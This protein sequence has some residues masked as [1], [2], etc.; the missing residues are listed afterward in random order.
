MD[1][2][3]AIYDKVKDVISKAFTAI[4]NFLVSSAANFAKFLDL[5]PEIS[6]TNEISW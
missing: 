6:F 1:K 5:E 2:L 3:K 4:K